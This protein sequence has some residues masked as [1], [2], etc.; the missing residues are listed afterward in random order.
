ML[1]ADSARG[2][3]NARYTTAIK[4]HSRSSDLR[5]IQ[6]RGKQLQHSRGQALIDDAS[7][8]KCEVG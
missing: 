1:Q 7:I 2:A 8:A 4:K 5:L 3:R 6:Y